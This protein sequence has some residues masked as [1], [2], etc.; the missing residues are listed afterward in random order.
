[1]QEVEFL[2]DMFFKILSHCYTP[3]PDIKLSIF[4]I[5]TEILTVDQVFELIDIVAQL[6]RDSIIA[7]IGTR[8]TRVSVSIYSPTS[9]IVEVAN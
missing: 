6:S 8:L 4:E 5:L 2:E 3:G 9:L 1:M 7:A